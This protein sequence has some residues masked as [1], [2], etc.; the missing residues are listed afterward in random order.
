MHRWQGP[1][2][3]EGSSVPLRMTEFVVT[4]SKGDLG[5]TLELSIQNDMIRGDLHNLGLDQH[6]LRT[7]RKDAFLLELLVTLLLPAG[8]DRRPQ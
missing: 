8:N 6:V 3:I 5:R 4:Y 2:S 7:R 1:C